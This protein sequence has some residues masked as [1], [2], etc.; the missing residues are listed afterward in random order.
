MTHK[1]KIGDKVVTEK[2]KIKGVI[3]EQNRHFGYDRV[4]KPTYGILTETGE[5]IYEWEYDLKPLKS[6][7]RNL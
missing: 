6:K 4:C 2:Y 3:T 7:Y 5:T 1:Y